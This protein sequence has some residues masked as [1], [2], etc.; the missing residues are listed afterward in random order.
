MEFSHRSGRDLINVAKKRTNVIPVIEDAR[1]P[2]KYRMLIGEGE[3]LGSKRPIWG[4]GFVLW[5]FFF[6]GGGIWGARLR[7]VG[8][9]GDH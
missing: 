3:V 7:C 4:L 5:E 6:G 2:H 1:H 9:R 8:G